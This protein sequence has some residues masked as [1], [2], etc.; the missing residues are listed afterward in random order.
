MADNL[1]Y[2]VKSLLDSDDYL[3]QIKLSNEI[4]KIDAN[5]ALISLG[6]LFSKLGCNEL[7]ALVLKLLPTELV[8]NN[9][10]LKKALDELGVDTSCSISDNTPDKGFT[11]EV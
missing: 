5:V 9:E 2:L 6:F 4:S 10:A 3:S 7:A 1:E 8:K 11:F